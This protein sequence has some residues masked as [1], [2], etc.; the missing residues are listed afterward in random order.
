[1]TNQQS[2]IINQQSTI[3]KPKLLIIDDDKGLCESLRDTI[4]LAGYLTEAAY[5]AE[6]GIKKLKEGFYNI[7]LLDMRLPNSHGMEVLDEIK[8]I[9][10]DTEVIIFTAFAETQDV[11]EA[12]E[13]NAFSYLP[14]PFETP[15]LLETI[16]KA[17][18]KQ[19]LLLEN[20]RLFEQIS[21]AKKD[22][23]NTFDS[24]Q[25]MVSI[26]DMELN[27]L[28]CNKAVANTFHARPAD[29]IG[30]KY[31][32][33]FH[34]K[35][36]KEHVK[37][38]F[39]ICKE[40]R[41]QE[42][43]QMELPQLGKTMQIT[44][45]PRFDERGDMIGVVQI[46]RDVTKQKSDEARIIR[47]SNILNAI[48][49]VFEEALTCETE[50]AIGTKCLSLAEKLTGSKFGFIGELNQETGLFDTIALSN[51]GWDACSIPETNAV[52]LIKD[53]KIRGIDR[54]LLKEEKSRIVNDPASHPDRV[55]M[56][57]G[58]PPITSFLGVPLKHNDRTFGMIGLGNKESGY[59]LEDQKAVE[60][61][62]VAFVEAITRVRIES[63]LM[64]N[65]EK[66]RTIS[67][68][69]NEAI[70]MVDNDGNIAFWNKAA[71]RIFGYSN[72]EAVGR[73]LPEL[74]IPSHLHERL[75]EGFKR[76]R[77]TGQGSLVGKTA[78]LTAMRK[79]GTE[80]P[81][82]H[83][84]S[85]VKMKDEWYAVGIIRDITERKQA[86]KELIVANKMASLGRL[87][88]GVFH[89]VLNPLQIISSYTQL[90]LLKEEKGSEKESYL[91]KIRHEVDRIV[92]IT[93]SL[94][95]FSRKGKLEADEF[96]LNSLLEN[97][98][99][100][101]EP[102]LKLKNIKCLIRFEDGLPE[103]SANCDELRQVF[104]N[105]IYNAKG[106]MPEGG[107]L[108]I[109]TQR[110][111][112]QGKSF[113]SIRFKDTGCGIKSDDIDKIFDPFF[114]TKPEGKG[115]GLGLSIS[116]GIIKNF[117][118]VMSVNSKEGKGTTFIIDLPLKD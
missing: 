102:D 96:D 21:Q 40:S 106:A 3:I 66:F 78:E 113:A 91:Q 29:L 115:T 33:V 75:L 100:I 51:P 42:T 62:S 22:W 73:S 36:K 54:S 26:H 8:K 12:M 92:K 41:E 60:T 61:L 53:M 83:S 105:L 70:I 44:C 2:S 81:I 99:E 118:G 39:T 14:K 86:E 94:L 68:M 89:E 52:K 13:R 11:I 59:D 65:E 34:C 56:P 58:H 19:R 67:D 72:E 48:N 25:D 116:Y 43:E 85:A 95:R 108:T 88:A 30:R 45:F 107:N 6:D 7:V 27:L 50:E 77:N 17:C 10:P 5:T 1:M 63:S 35:N 97:I 47:Q 82:E 15:K 76:F 90:L 111:E 32:D 57:K 46:A 117:G 55:G 20:R 28:K 37:C 24:I 79:N 93:D 114:T 31:Y 103:I 84:L 16:E 80:F 64:D 38:P 4:E 87:S 71:E 18:E 98:R 101:V 74:I 109:S 9:S 49:E 112:K 104:L 69:A 110:I 23:E